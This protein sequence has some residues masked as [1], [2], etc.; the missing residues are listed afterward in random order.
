ME[1]DIRRGAIAKTA[2]HGSA[3]N[4]IDRRDCRNQLRALH[5]FDMA[6]VE[7]PQREALQR[8]GFIR[9]AAR[10][11]PEV[12][13]A[14]LQAFGLARKAGAAFNARHLAAVVMGLCRA[15]RMNADK[16]LN[17]Q[18]LFLYGLKL[19]FELAGLFIDG[20]ELVVL[21]RRQRLQGRELRLGL[22]QL[23]LMHT[24]GREARGNEQDRGA[25]DM[26]PGEFKT[27]DGVP[28]ARHYFYEISIFNHHTLSPRAIAIALS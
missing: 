6:K 22:V 14:I 21:R 28:T 7:D 10:R 2:D 9:G 19:R 18:I 27:V 25:D 26:A 5:G 3:I 24:E 20:L 4:W 1:T 8:L 13:Q 23:I 11:E 16:L 17:L 12:T 15:V